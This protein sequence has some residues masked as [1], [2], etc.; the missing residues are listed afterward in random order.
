MGS[1]AWRTVSSELTVT[2]S[3]YPPVVLLVAGTGVA[4]AAALALGGTVGAKR[5]RERPATLLRSE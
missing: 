5:W 1:R 3:F 4:L 2:P